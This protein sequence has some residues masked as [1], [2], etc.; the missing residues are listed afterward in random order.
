MYDCCTVC[1]PSAIFPCKIQ[2][3]FFPTK[4]LP[5]GFVL[6]IGTC[7][8]KAFRTNDISFQ[9]VWRIPHFLCQFSVRKS[10]WREVSP[11]K[12]ISPFFWYE[13]GRSKQLPWDSY[14][15]YWQSTLL[16]MPIP[17]VFSFT[18]LSLGL[19][20]E[21]SL[22]NGTQSFEEDIP[23]TCQ[24]FFP[25]TNPEFHVDAWVKPLPSF[26]CTASRW[27]LCCVRFSKEAGAAQLYSRCRP[28]FKFHRVLLSLEILFPPPSHPY[29]LLS[30]YGCVSASLW[31]RRVILAF[32]W[33]VGLQ[34]K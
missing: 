22:W 26:C 25:S 1:T 5:T 12:N 6:T 30:S 23:H 31:L 14:I 27:T 24:D 19:L 4:L 11:E 33:W 29:F 32:T 2:L 20:K 18:L 13:G 34:S 3:L 9:L 7:K 28:V 10:S 16:Q 8:M 21:L 17:A 15:G